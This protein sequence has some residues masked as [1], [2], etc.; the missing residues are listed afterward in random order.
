MGLALLMGFK[1]PE[2]FR[3]PYTATNLVDFWHRWHISLSTWL[4]DYLYISLGGN[5]KGLGGKYLNLMITMV[6]GGLWHGAHSRFLLWGA[7][8]GLGLTVTHI[9]RDWKKSRISMN[10][11][12]HLPRAMRTTGPWDVA[13]KFAGWFLTFHFV[14]FL[15]VFFR[16]E[17]TA[18]AFDIFGSALAFT[19]PGDGFEFWVIPAVLTGLLMQF[20]GGYIRRAYLTVQERLP[21]PLQAATIGLCCIV[22]LRL[23]PD[24]VLPFIY[25]Q[26]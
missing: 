18:R 17:D 7:L 3:Q 20:A 10:V 5:R 6:L 19:R 13:R 8:H 1:I 21:V 2:N 16:A 9:Y 24:G 26:F 14:T 11:R 4:R 22:I 23:G 15:W 12:D 25:F